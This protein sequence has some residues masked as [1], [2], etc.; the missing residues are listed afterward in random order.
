MASSCLVECVVRAI[1]EGEFFAVPA[2]TDWCF[3]GDRIHLLHGLGFVAVERCDGVELALD[4]GWATRCDC[5]ARGETRK[6]ERCDECHFFFFLGWC[7]EATVT[8]VRGCGW[9]G[10]VL[11]LGGLA[12]NLLMLAG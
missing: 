1:T 8:G 7:G 12:S 6:G 10:T 3:T 4:G 5:A 9:Y 2:T 11:V